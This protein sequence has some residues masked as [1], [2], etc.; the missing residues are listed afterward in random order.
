[1][2]SWWQSDRKRWQEKGVKIKR[3]KSGVERG[4]KKGKWR[5]N[6]D[7]TEAKREEYKM[8]GMK[9]KIYYKGIEKRRSK[10]VRIRRKARNNIGKKVMRMDNKI[11][12]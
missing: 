7:Y 3:K 8:I 2:S 5:K 11:E 4:R 1:M 10:Y 12:G 6:K 9:Y